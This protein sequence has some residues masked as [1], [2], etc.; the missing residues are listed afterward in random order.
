MKP[1]SIANRILCNLVCVFHCSLFCLSMF[2]CLSISQI[3]DEMSRSWKEKKMQD[4][5]CKEIF[6]I[7]FYFINFQFRKCIFKS[8]KQAICWTPSLFQ[9]D[10]SFERN[11]LVDSSI[12]LDGVTKNFILEYFI[13][14]QIDTTDFVNTSTI[15]DV[16]HGN[17][18]IEVHML[19][20]M[21]LVN[22][23]VF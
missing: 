7:K 22:R 6:L 5:H 4:Y 2:L 12:H 9:V 20:N 13:D 21:T 15:L 19:W 3:I 18:F 17:L 16:I 10:R 8:D 23:H 11:A 14:P 1:P